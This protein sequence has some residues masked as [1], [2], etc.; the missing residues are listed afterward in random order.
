M[1]TI[2]R[3]LAKRK[4]RTVCLTVV[5][6]AMLAPIFGARAESASESLSAPRLMAEPAMPAPQPN[7]DEVQ[8]RS[9]HPWQAKELLQSTEGPNWRVFAV[10]AAAC[11]SPV[12]PNRKGECKTI[13]RECERAKRFA[14]IYSAPI[15]CST[16]YQQTSI[17]LTTAKSP[18]A[19]T[20][21]LGD[22]TLPRDSS[23]LSPKSKRQGKLAKAKVRKASEAKPAR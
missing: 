11:E 3:T 10:E 21:W 18:D 2:F 4:L 15:A 17:L 22:A 13:A 19:Q 9:L 12:A 23:K 8:I 6:V 16:L 1:S 5:A 14:N 20:G 7:Q